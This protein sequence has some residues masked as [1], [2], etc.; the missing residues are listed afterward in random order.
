M[1]KFKSIVPALKQK[2][3]EEVKMLLH[4]SRDCLRNQKRDTTKISFS[5]TDGYYGEAFGVMRALQLLGYGKFSS[6]NLNGIE[7]CSTKIQAVQPEQNLK[8]WF[9]QLEDKVLKEEGYG[10]GNQCDH[11]FKRWGKDA[12]RNND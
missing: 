12:V 5:V 4:A 6:S 2:V 10:S 7:D 9:R 1:K 11:C 8:W 3:E